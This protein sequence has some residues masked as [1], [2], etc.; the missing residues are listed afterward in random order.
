M[1]MPQTHTSGRV[2]VIHLALI[3]FNVT[4]SDVDATRPILPKIPLNEL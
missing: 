4:F 1:A 2:Y 3:K